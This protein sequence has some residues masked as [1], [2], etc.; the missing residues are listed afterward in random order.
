[1]SA[2]SLDC[3]DLTSTCKDQGQ[4]RRHSGTASVGDADGGRSGPHELRAG[5]TARFSDRSLA[6]LGGRF[7]PGAHVET[8]CRSLGEWYTMNAVQEKTS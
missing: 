1:M 7:S 3:R 5:R 6:I 2:I 8:G 4:E